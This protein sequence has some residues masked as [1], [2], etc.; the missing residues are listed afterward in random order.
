MFGVSVFS[1][2]M[3]RWDCGNGRGR[4]APLREY[5]T[6][7]R[8]DCREDGAPGFVVAY[9][10][11]A[12]VAVA[13]VGFAGVGLAAFVDDDDAALDDDFRSEEV[14]VAVVGVAAEDQDVA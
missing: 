10:D 8:W 3:K 12:L 5:P 9:G 11:D 6:L 4:F 2:R 1:F 13:D 14:P 7:R